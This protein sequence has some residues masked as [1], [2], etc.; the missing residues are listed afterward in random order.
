LKLPFQMSWRIRIRMRLSRFLPLI[1]MEMH[2]VQT[3]NSSIIKRRL[4]NWEIPEGGPEAH[5]QW[6]R[7]LFSKRLPWTRAAY[8]KI[9]KQPWTRMIY[10]KVTISW[11]NL[12]YWIKQEVMKI[13]WRERKS[14]IK[15]HKWT[16]KI[17]G[18]SI[19][20]KI[21]LQLAT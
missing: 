3:L 21:K 4:E 10:T 1:G 15:H 20:K 6:W 16:S 9:L 17:L 2:L 12:I 11:K 5:H 8:S 13:S 14:H 18:N 7:A 19:S